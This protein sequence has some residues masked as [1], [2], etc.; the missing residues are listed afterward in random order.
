MVVTRGDESTRIVSRG[1]RGCLADEIYYEVQRNLKAI[2]C[3]QS[4]AR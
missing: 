3:A 1:C 4:P 2:D